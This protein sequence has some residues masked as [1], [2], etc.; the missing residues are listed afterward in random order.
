MWT[1]AY[2]IVWFKLYSSMIYSIGIYG[3]I[4]LAIFSDEFIDRAQGLDSLVLQEY[5]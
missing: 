4:F 5:E 2:D 3:Y 1:I